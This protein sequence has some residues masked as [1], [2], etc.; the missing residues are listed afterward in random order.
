MKNYAR[1]ESG[2]VIEII[3]PMAYEFDADDGSNKA[4]DEIPI[5]KRFPAEFVANLIDVT[6]ITPQPDCG[7]SYDGETFSAPVLVPI[8]YTTVNFVQRN[9]LMDVANAARCGMSDACI[10]GLLDLSDVATFKTWAA[11][12]LALSKIDLTLKSPTWPSVPT[13]N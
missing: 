13:S 4:G 12:K 11:Y 10:V 6:S 2:I 3:A 1:I 7:W 9:D 8:N 5:E